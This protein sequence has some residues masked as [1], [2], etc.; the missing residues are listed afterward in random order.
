M[1]CFTMRALAAATTLVATGITHAQSTVTLYGIVDTGIE[2]YN[3]SAS[4]GAF[5]GM[6]T[7]TGELP[8]RWGLRGTEELGGGYTAF[9]VLESGFAVSNGALNYG[10]RLFGRQANMGIGTPYGSLTLGRQMNMTMY[11]LS[12]ADVIGPS[13]HSMASFD[14][15]LPNSRSDNAIGYMGVFH[16]LKLGATYSFGRDAAGPAGPSATNCPGQVPGNGLAC[17]QYTLLAGY[18]SSRFGVALSY[19]VMRGG[20][21][22]MAPLTSPSDIDTH[23]VADG[24]INYGK[25]KLGAGWIRRNLDTSRHMQSDI[26]FVGGSY[27]LS[28]AL[29]V[30]AQGLRY[31]QKSQ[32]SSTL[33]I[34]RLDYL[35]S[36]RTTVYSSVAYMLNSPLANSPAAAGG[37]VAM[38]RNQ[39]GVMAGVQQRF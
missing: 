12:N 34:A 23:L 31:I 33:L 16:G 26:F 22:A 19:D 39:L 30:D 36:K 21:G 35:L 2:Y 20:G 14:G 13:I 1:K 4:H 9:F 18:D 10:G 25:G 3:N 5:V 7:L 29:S 28:P 32:S 38:G 24:Y 6:P 17:R 11:A 8:S 15:Y 27:A 37:T